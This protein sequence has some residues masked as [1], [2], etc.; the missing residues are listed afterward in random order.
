MN[1]KVKIEKKRCLN[2]CIQE[3]IVRA[4]LAN[5]NNSQLCIVEEIKNND[6]DSCKCYS[7]KCSKR[8]MD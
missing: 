5:E 6:T 2:K 3:P 1:E 8:Y 7:E 4:T